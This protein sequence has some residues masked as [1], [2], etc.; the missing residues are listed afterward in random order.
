MK[1]RKDK[2]YVDDII[3]AMGKIQKYTKGLDYERFVESDLIID[4]TLRNIEVIGEASKNVSVELR[5][6]YP[7]IPWKRM[8]G[9][10]NIVTHEYF[11]VDLGIIWVIAN[12][13][14]PE[15]IPLIKNMLKEFN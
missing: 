7:N 12:E 4:A 9:L 11:G 14:I 1:K 2:L 8:I 6:K 15:T 10:R 5:G 13:N 3:L